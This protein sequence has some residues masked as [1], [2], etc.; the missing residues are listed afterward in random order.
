M[1]K[2]LFILMILL[3]ATSF[4]CAGVGAYYQAQHYMINEV[5]FT[6]AFWSYVGGVV[7]MLLYLLSTKPAH[8]K[9]S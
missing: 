7:F 9:P 3:S 1:K 6:I 8:G 4:I 2:I 5:Y